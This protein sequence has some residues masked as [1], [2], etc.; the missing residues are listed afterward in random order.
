MKNKRK[1]SFKWITCKFYFI[2]NYMLHHSVIFILVVLKIFTIH[3]LTHTPPIHP[4]SR[5]FIHP[6][7]NASIHALIH[8]SIHSFIH[9]PNHGSKHYPYIILS[10]IIIIIVVVVVVVIIIIIIIIVVV[11]IIIIIIE[12]RPWTR[13]SRC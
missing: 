9:A 2:I 13:L 5:L 1:T 3:S 7:I 12:I 8:P 10:I 4:F 11:I 6:S